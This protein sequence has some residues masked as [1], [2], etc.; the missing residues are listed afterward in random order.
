M[1]SKVLILSIDFIPICLIICF[2]LMYIPNNKNE[3]EIKSLQNVG[4]ISIISFFISLITIIMIYYKVNDLQYLPYTPFILYFIV[5]FVLPN[6][7]IYFI[8]PNEK[9]L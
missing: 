6:F 8:K 3:N 1:D 2:I 9:Q 5:F 4:K 7:Y